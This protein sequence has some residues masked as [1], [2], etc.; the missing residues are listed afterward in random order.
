MNGCYGDR[1]GSCVRRIAGNGGYLFLNLFI[2][3]STLSPFF[4]PPPPPPPPSPSP[5]PPPHPSPGVLLSKRTMGSCAW[6]RIKMEVNVAAPE[7]GVLRRFRRTWGRMELWFLGFFP[8]GIFCISVP[9]DRA[10]LSCGE[11]SYCRGLGL[12]SFFFFFFTSLTIRP[13]PPPPPPAIPPPPPL[14]PP[15][16]CCF[17]LKK[18]QVDP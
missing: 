9:G 14:P 2:Y 6:N 10:E 5:P 7:L 8:S 16:P 17:P 1:R 4:S 11:L 15:P 18:E 12:W 3:F 13:S